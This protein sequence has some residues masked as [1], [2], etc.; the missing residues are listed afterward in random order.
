MTALRIIGAGGHGKVVA[1]V[2]DAVGYTDIAFLDDRFPNVVRNGRFAVVGRPTNTGRFHA[3][4]AIG[5]NTIRAQISLQ[6]GLLDSPMLIH[7][8]AIIS[9][10]VQLGAGSVAMAQVVVNADATI[11]QG[12]ILNTACSVDH[13]CRLGDFTHI[14]PGA[15]LA[16]GVTVGARSW[17]GIGAVVREGVTIGSDVVVAAGAAVV[18]D[19]SDGIR[20][21]G[22]P[23]KQI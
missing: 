23:A 3:F 13:D 10:S 12:V 7:P 17:I 6:L 21:G 2:A 5:S 16:G 15:R 19:I 22:V 8:S 4:C 11:G 14:S 1:D 20:V 18:S 9:A